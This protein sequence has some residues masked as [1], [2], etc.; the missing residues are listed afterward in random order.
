[1]S[2]SVVKPSHRRQ[3]MWVY[4]I[5]GLFLCDFVLCGYLPSQQRLASLQQAQAQ[6]QQ[7]GPHG[8]GP[9]ARS[10][11][12][13]SRLRDT[14]KPRNGSIPTCRSDNALG[15]FL[16]RIAAVM[17][18]SELTEQVVLPGKEVETED[19]GCIPIHMACKGTLTNLFSFFSSLQALDRL[20]RIEKV[21]LENDTDLTGRLTLQTE[22]VIF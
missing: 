21:A 15:A 14:E 7:H 11:P 4:V 9:A 13:S 3:Q 8:G 16:Q 19:L 1:M 5:A 18:E 10:C 2:T 6:Q 12:V 20:V 17:T 22:A